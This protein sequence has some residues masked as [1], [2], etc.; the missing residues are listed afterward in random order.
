MSTGRRLDDSGQAFPIYV[1]AV[2][3]LLFVALAF[4]AVGMAGDTRSEAQSA[5]DAAALAAAREARDDVFVGVNLIDLKPTDWERILNGESFD[6][7]GACGEAESFAQRN[8]ATTV[9]CE[10]VLPRF[11]VSVKTSRTVG[12]SVVPGTG[13]MHGEAV[14]TAVIKP[15]CSLGLEPA[16][17]ATPVPPDGGIPEPGPVNITCDGR[18]IDLD[19]LNPGQLSKLAR[20]LFSVRLVG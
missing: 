4:F 14:A 11:T 6:V 18:P 3:G 16:P 7:K 19:P 10:V 1:I 15:L 13:S 8:D 17:T 5:A 12:E 2:V 9:R 20:T